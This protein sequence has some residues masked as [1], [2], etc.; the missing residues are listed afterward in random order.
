MR[1]LVQ[2]VKGGAKV[3]VDQQTV[4]EIDHGFLVLLGAMGGDTDE[5]AAWICKKLLS[6]R[7]FGDEAGKMNRSIQDVGGQILLVSQFTL[8]ADVARGNRP[9][10]TAAMAPEAAKA[11]FDD[12]CSRLQESVPV[13][14]GIFGADMKVSL[15]N[16]GPVTIWLDSRERNKA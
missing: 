1:A 7:I 4:G 14:T 9:S 10:F 15:C 13:A 8:C 6:L 5:D 11:M 3:V 12:V 2:R 16:D